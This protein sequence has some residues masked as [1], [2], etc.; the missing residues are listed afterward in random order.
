MNNN[1]YLDNADDVMEEIDSEIE[2]ASAPVPIYTI[3]SYPTDPTLETLHLRW[4]RDEIEI[5]EFQRGWVW[6]HAQASQLVESF[7]L[8]LPVPGI[9]LYR[10]QPSQH[11][12]VIDGQQRLR[13]IFG[14]IEGKLPDVS[15][16]SLRDVDQRW[17]GK[18]YTDLAESD[19]IRFRDAVL[20]AVVIEQTDPNDNSSMYH[21]F[22]RLNTGGTHLNPQ[23]VRNS[24]AHGPFNDLILELN[25]F[26]E[27]RKIF[28]REARDPRMR[29]VELVVRFCALRDASVTYSKPM[30]KF[31]NDY[32]KRH[33]FEKSK[34]PTKGIF[35]S[36]VRRVLDSL[37]PTPFH[38]ARGINVAVYDSAMLAFSGANQIPTDIVSRWE[39]LLQN[40]CYIDA[41]KSATTD[42]K[43]VERRIAIAS[44]I[45]FK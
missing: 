35:E 4:Q 8:G 39:K 10:E 30:K 33:Q 28:G 15:D 18:R 24:A 23:E 1:D 12:L 34:E 16:F 14:F 20:R 9:F 21:V 27:W 41:I 38:I 43:T 17:A 32:M 42:E 44:E 36:T 6:K 7:L 25:E 13:T 26:D 3:S 45:L 2:D 19:R 29:D 11:Y 40:T 37:G 22:E 31:L 5:P